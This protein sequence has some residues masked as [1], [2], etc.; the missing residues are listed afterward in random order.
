MSL[1]LDMGLIDASRLSREW[2]QPRFGRVYERTLE[3]YRTLATL[4]GRLSQCS[5]TLPQM[6]ARKYTYAAQTKAH[7]QGP[8]LSAE[9]AVNSDTLSPQPSSLPP[10]PPSK[11]PQGSFAF[12]INFGSVRPRFFFTT[13]DT[14]ICSH[15]PREDLF[16]SR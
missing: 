13:F 12:S 4:S 10:P 16:F 3:L 11:S 8:M 15:R 14:S 2:K 1:T 7:S 5:I 9:L 6:G